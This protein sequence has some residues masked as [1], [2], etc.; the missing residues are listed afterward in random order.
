MPDAS[1]AQLCVPARWRPSQP[2]SG[3]GQRISVPFNEAP[4]WSWPKAVWG[5]TEGRVR[6]RCF[7]AGLRISMTLTR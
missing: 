3:G 7:H 5:A 2:F 4:I 1:W 6:L